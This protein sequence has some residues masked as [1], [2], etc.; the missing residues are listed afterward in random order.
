M[1]RGNW[2]KKVMD[3]CLKEN[4]GVKTSRLDG[5]AAE[6]LKYGSDTITGAENIQKVYGNMG[7]A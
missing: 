7:C 2:R 5:I 4:E 3:G 1:V 6:M